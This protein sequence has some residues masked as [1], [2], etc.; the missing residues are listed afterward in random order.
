MK[1]V[2]ILQEYV[3]QYRNAFFERLITLGAEDSIHIKVAAGRPNASQNMR[4]DQVDAAFVLPIK[5]REFRVGSYRFV[6]RNTRPATRDADLIVMEQA[7]RNIDAYALL[8]SPWRRRKICLWGHGRDFV[9]RPSRLSRA[10][11]ARL[12]TAADWFFAYTEGSRAAVVAAG[13]PADKT[14]VVNNSIDTDE[15]QKQM[16]DISSEEIAAFRRK[17]DLTTSTALFMGGLD[18]SK[19]LPFLLEAGRRAHRK[20]AD[21]RL[22]VIG[23]GDQKAYVE[24]TAS[25]EP[26]LTYLG[27]RFGK[28]KALAI[29]SSAILAM[30][31]RVGL[32]AV[33]SFA[34]G[35][36]IVTTTWPWH[37]P[38]FEY[39]IDGR[40]SLM[41][42]D[43]EE[44]YA[45]AV[46]ALLNDKERLT[47]M[48]QWCRDSM[49]EYSID[50]MA[51]RFFRGIQ[52]ALAS[53][54]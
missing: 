3:P 37:G 51:S 18:E 39:L 43:D 7:R 29:A 35:R 27:P 12:T 44:A 54:Q 8:F 30:P 9:R 2:V 34:A 25:K 38:E 31:G 1:T 6:L 16:A 22:V 36:P 15:L 48:Q 4:Q 5:Q 11:M 28:Q 49:A 19:R 13:F 33:D 46:V 52:M 17:Y 45:N 23:S 42:V 24:S 21:F 20:D 41:S 50:A 32:I 47:A 26:W 14:T 10:L 53:T 40:T